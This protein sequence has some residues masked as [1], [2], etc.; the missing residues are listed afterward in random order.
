MSKPLRFA[1]IG[2]DHRH[3]YHLVGELIAAGAECAGYCSAT[4]DQRVLQG[5]RERFPNPGAVDRDQLLADLSIDFIVIAAIPCDR[6]G[7]AVRAMQ[8]GRM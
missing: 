6:S 7:I 5:F 3:V 4:S 2:L 1:A 8:A